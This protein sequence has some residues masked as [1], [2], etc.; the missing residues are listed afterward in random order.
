M[1][2]KHGSQNVPASLW[3][4]FPLEPYRLIDQPE[5]LPGPVVPK[6]ETPPETW[7]EVESDEQSELPDD[8]DPE[9]PDN[10]ESDA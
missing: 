3:V 2:M 9:M 4:Y 5:P 1:A 10:T 6:P 8:T 7:E